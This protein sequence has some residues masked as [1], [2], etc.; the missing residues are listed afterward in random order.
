MSDKISIR[1]F[2]N[3]P[4]RAV[5]D[6]DNSKWWFSVLDIIAIFNTE[7]DYSRVRNYWKYLKNK[8]KKES[9]QLVSATNQLKLK[10]PDGKLRLTDVMDAASVSQLAKVM[11]NNKAIGFLDWF[12][13]SE[14][15][16]DG[17]SRKKAYDLF[18]SGLLKKTRAGQHQ[19][20]ATNP[21]LYI[22]RSL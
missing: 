17:R 4:V 8:L 22:R 18:E 21:R 6:E 20:P 12:T 14:N 10:A 13:Y 16:L 7:D 19:V 3:R 1:F 15:T 9:S 2:G 5:W 11:P